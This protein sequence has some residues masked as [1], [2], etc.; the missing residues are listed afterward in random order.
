MKYYGD[1]PELNLHFIR[2]SADK[3]LI[4]ARGNCTLVIGLSR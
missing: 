3:L 4:G 1:E 2:L